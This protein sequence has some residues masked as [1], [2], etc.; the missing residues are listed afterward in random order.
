MFLGDR[1]HLV[2]A[3]LADGVANRLV[4]VGQG[5]CHASPNVCRYQNSFDIFNSCKVSPTTF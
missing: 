2:F 3:E 1:Y 4:F 5:E